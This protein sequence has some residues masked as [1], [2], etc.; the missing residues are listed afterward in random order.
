MRKKAGP[1]T[2]VFWGVMPFLTVYIV[3]IFVLLAVPEIALYLVSK[4]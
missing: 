1:V 2:D 3:A 4:R